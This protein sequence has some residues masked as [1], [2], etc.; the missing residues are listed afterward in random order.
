MQW[1][2]VMFYYSILHAGME[3][4]FIYFFLQWANFFACLCNI[5]H[6]WQP[7]IYIL[8]ETQSSDICKVVAVEVWWKQVIKTAV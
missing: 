6:L 7:V 5:Q 1:K 8:E 3:N 4:F 2:A